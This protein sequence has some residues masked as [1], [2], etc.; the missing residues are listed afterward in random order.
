MEEYTV[1]K[2]VNKVNGK[3]YIGITKQLP[4]ERWGD[5]GKNYKEKCPAFWNA[6]E[7]YGWDA[8]EH[9]IVAAGLSRDEACDLEITLIR[10]EMTQDRAHGYNILSGGSA[11]SIPEEVRAKMSAAMAG[12]K[13]GLG[14]PCSEQKRAKISAAQKGRR[15]SEEHKRKLS[16]AKKGKPHAPPSAETRKKIS[17]SHKKKKVLCAETNTVY[18][19]IQECARSLGVYATFVCKCCKNKQKSTGGYHFQYFDDVINA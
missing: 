13:N 5:G 8:F 15:L 2:H 17:D 7:K 19:S 4:Q 11:P 10:N 6:I 14:K 18:E 1:Y 16:A 9:V 12:N 3:Q